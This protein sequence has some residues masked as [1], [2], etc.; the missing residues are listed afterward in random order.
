MIRRVVGTRSEAVLLTL[1]APE[2]AGVATG[3]VATLSSIPLHVSAWVDFAGAEPAGVTGFFPAG[4]RDSTKAST[5]SSSQP[6]ELQPSGLAK[7]VQRRPA[8]PQ[9]QQHLIPSEDA[10]VVC[11]SGMSC[12]GCHATGILEKL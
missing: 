4:R 9:P 10:R 7:A 5:S 12:L 6:A 1:T 8:T 11:A 3:A 2:S